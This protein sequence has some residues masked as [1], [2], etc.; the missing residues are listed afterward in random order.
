MSIT[1]NKESGHFMETVGPVVA[2]GVR[3]LA[4]RIGELEA[5]E[6]AAVQ[7]SDWPAATSAA[8]EKAKLKEVQHRVVAGSKRGRA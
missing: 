2:A 5:E 1:N 8:I 3:L 7:R 6:R 4:D